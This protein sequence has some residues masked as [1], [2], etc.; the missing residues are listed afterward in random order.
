MKQV[1]RDLINLGHIHSADLSLVK[2]LGNVLADAPDQAIMMGLK[3][4]ESFTGFFSIPTFKDLCQITAADLGLPDVKSAYY[5][6][7][8]STSPV[9]NCKFTHPIVYHAG[10]L[11][12]WFELRNMEEFKVFPLFKLR[13]EELTKKILN[14]ESIAEPEQIAIAP[15]SVVPLSKF[16]NKNRF[17]E[18]K[19]NLK[20]YEEEI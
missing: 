15:H 8:K 10:R 16:E 1:L 11:T 3:K 7:A 18:M 12:G 9:T 13:Y 17:A 4:A 2:T 14:G 19:K 20:I 6:A 5:E